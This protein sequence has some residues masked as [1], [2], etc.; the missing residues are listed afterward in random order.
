[1]NNPLHEYPLTRKLAKQLITP[2]GASRV[3][4]HGEP[5]VARGPV[6][7]NR[8]KNGVS[9]AP[10]A[11]Q[12]VLQTCYIILLNRSLGGMNACCTN[13]VVI[14]L[15][16]KRRSSGTWSLDNLMDWAVTPK[17]QQP[18]MVTFYDSQN[19]GLA[20]KCSEVHCY[21]AFDWRWKLGSVLCGSRYYFLLWFYPRF[22]R[23]NPSNEHNGIITN[24]R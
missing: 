21:R 15:W 7:R 2:R 24:Y 5:T 22:E 1:M 12:P 20:G 23:F 17:K 11:S 16:V 10:L 18:E 9:S 3:E 19:D 14:H 13:C 4:E 8:P 6:C